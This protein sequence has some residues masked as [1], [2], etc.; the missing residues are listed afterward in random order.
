MLWPFILITCFISIVA[1]R[2]TVLLQL[3]SFDIFKV[4]VLISS[5][6]YGSLTE[7]LQFI[8]NLDIKLPE[9]LYKFDGESIKSSEL[10]E[11]VIATSVDNSN[12]KN[13]YN[14]FDGLELYLFLFSKFIKKSRYKKFKLMKI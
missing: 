2:I 9:D 8:N 7:I 5:I 6:N 3:L 4:W 14:N 1:L 13:R 11:G 12:L 10:K